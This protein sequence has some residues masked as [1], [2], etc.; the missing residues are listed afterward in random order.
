MLDEK[1]NQ[2]TLDYAQRQPRPAFWVDLL[3]G[4]IGVFWA[5]LFVRDL[6]AHIRWRKA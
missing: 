2:T 6:R 5:A 1:P 4:V 3:L